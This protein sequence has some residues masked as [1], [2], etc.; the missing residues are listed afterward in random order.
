MRQDWTR[1]LNT[2]KKDSYAIMHDRNS[3]RWIQFVLNKFNMCACVVCYVLGMCDGMNACV[4]LIPELETTAQPMN[5]ISVAL[6]H[7]VHSNEFTY[8]NRM[9]FP[10]E[11]MPKCATKSNILCW[12]TCA[13]E[14]LS[15]YYYFDLFT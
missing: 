2:L 7:V 9:K 14:T 8:G 10:I 4:I 5:K 6:A 13:I 1:I 11:T 3:H 15:H 12:P